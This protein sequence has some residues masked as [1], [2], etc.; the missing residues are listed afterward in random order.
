MIYTV[1]LNPSIDYVLSV[2]EY[3]NGGL[4]RTRSEVFLPGGKGNNVSIV[5]KNLGVE[6]TAMGFC[7]GFTGRELE[8]MLYRRGISTDYVH[9]EEGNSRVNVKMHSLN[10]HVETEING[11][12]PGISRQALAEL[13]GKLDKL[14]KGDFLVL[15]GSIPATAPDTVYEDIC[16]MLSPRGVRIVVDAEKKLLENVLPF[17][18]FLIKPNLAELEELFGVNLRTREEIVSCAQKLREKGARNVMVSLAGQGAVFVGEDKTVICMEAPRGEVVN[19]V[20][21]GDS[22]V[23]GFLAQTMLG[24]AIPEAFEFA[25]YCGSACAFMQGLPEK[26]DIEK[27]RKESGR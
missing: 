3:K 1:T 17:R 25:V 5:L 13:K 7:A 8:A 4:N 22:M 26:E 11:N 2:E 23:A 9:L 6:N 21:A 15:A 12:G 27:V 16:R 24:K 14:Q 19:S 18:P 10:D 20:G